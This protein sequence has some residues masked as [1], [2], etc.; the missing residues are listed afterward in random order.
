MPGTIIGCLG[1]QR[2][3]KTLFAY[4]LVKAIPSLNDFPSLRTT[5][6]KEIMDMP[7]NMDSCV[8]QY[9]QSAG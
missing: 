1:A 9:L 6:E 8:Y 7:Y 5:I 3:G 4:K 2:S